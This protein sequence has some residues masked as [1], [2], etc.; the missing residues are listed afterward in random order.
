MLE[1]KLKKRDS[2]KSELNVT[3]R[4]KERQERKNQGL[5]T[6]TQRNIVTLRPN[7]IRETSLIF[8]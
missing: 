1:T 2:A 3:I 8:F 6:N 5:G 7:F 4:K